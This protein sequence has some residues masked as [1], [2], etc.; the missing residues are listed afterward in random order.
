M[1]IVFYT[2]RM[3]CNFI[4]GKILMKTSQ[5]SLSELRIREG[6]GLA[7]A[8]LSKLASNWE[9]LDNSRIVAGHKGLNLMMICTYVCRLSAWSLYT[10][11]SVQ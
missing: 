9:L 8:P 6:S 3:S 1:F 2:W 5:M 7:G 10:I 4:F 11:S